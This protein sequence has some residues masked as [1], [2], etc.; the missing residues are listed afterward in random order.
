MLNSA[1]IEFGKA[2][3]NVVALNYATV[4][5]YE[6]AMNHIKHAEF[7]ETLKEFSMNHVRHIREFSEVLEDLGKEAPAGAG[8]K[9]LLRQG[10]VIFANLIGDKAILK[11][12][13]LNEDDTNRAYEKLNKHPGKAAYITD[14]LTKG[15]N[16]EKRHRDWLEET[17][18]GME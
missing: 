2:L 4:A 17:I 3:K 13:K 5:S 11:A 16:D 10:R 18:A 1:Q 8:I 9:Q 14:P 6:E 7:K 15:L 12:L